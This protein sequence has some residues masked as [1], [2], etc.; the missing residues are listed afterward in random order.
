MDPVNS[1]RKFLRLFFYSVPAGVFIS[2][3]AACKNQNKQDEKKTGGD[4]CSDLS[5]LTEND[6]EA[7]KSLGYQDKAPLHDKR[8]ATCSLF[9][10]AKDAKDCGKCTLFKGPINPGGTCTYWSAKNTNA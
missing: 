10:P 9:L 1:R 2:T 5:G 4:P 6:L 3:V 8:C 7:R